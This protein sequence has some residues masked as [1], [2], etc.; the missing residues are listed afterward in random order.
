MDYWSIGLK[1]STPL[2][3]HS[4]I[5][6]RC[7]KNPPPAAEGF[8]QADTLAAYFRGDSGEQIILSALDEQKDIVLVF[9]L[10][11]LL[12]KIVYVFNRFTVDLADDIAGL[13]S[14]VGC[15]TSW[16]NASDHHA[17]LTFSRR[18][19]AIAGVRFCTDIPRV[20]SWAGSW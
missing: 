7:K 12:H 1:C 16:F 14:R 2:L 19:L 11:K 20:L 8:L 10:F 5:P 15:R 3:H 17:G 9:G 6:V 4:I 18:R 13:N